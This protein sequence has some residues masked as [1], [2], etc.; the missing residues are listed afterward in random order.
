MLANN[1]AFRLFLVTT[2]NRCVVRCVIVESLTGNLSFCHFDIFYWLEFRVITCRILPMLSIAYIVHPA[3]PYERHVRQS[4]AFW[5]RPVSMVTHR[6][7]ESSSVSDYSSSKT[8]NYSCVIIVISFTRNRTCIASFW[9]VK[10]FFRFH[11]RVH[12]TFTLPTVTFLKCLCFNYHGIMERFAFY[13]LHLLLQL[14][15]RRD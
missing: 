11:R 3:T 9:L 12:S 6:I 1:Y 7:G 5:L 15:A 2:H 8:S 4:C 10:A 14:A 13:N